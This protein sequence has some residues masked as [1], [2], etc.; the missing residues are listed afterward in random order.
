M[1]A[2]APDPQPTAPRVADRLAWLVSAAAS[3]F[4][5]LALFLGLL[6]WHLA[7]TPG[8]AA[9]WA[10]LAIGGIVA[11][12]AVYVVWAV[13]AGHITDVH[14][15]L[16]E[17]RAAPFVAAIA[18]CGLSAALLLA[19]NAHPELV[20]ASL[21][22]LVNGLLFLAVTL[23]WKIAMHPAILTACAVMA[24]Q[25][26]APQWYWALLAVPLVI[27]ARLQRRRHTLAQCLTGTVLAGAATW[28]M[29]GLYLGVIGSNR[30]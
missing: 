24:G 14:V 29:T 28:A 26:I 20:L 30:P 13:L 4:L 16:R 10:A 12:P 9:R 27:W 5:V 22:A 3:P 21:A 2:A 18:G 7:P 6:A 8:I 15:Q 19:S 11:V 23:R 1:Y 25:L 17:Q